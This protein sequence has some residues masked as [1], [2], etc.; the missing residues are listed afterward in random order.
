LIPY[1]AAFHVFDALQ[2]AVG[3][4]LRAHKRAVAPTVVYALTLWGVGLVGGYHVAF[5][6]LGGPP[7]GVTGI[8]L[9]QAVGLALAGLLLL[10]F[11]LWLL[12]RP[13]GFDREPRPV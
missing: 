12:R 13:G 8:W 6:G 7:W 3:F 9:M 11:Y 1:L 5:R 2:T 4:V 10:G